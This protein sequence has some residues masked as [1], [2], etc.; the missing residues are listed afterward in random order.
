MHTRNGKR[1]KILTLFIRIAGKFISFTVNIYIHMS[2]VIKFKLQLKILQQT[3]KAL[4]LVI[5]KETAVTTLT[6]ISF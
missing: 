4:E 1:L 3:H 5:N 2:Q 6:I